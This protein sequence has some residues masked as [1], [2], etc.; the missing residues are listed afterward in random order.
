MACRWYILNLNGGASPSVRRSI[1]STAT[2]GRASGRPA[3]CSNMC[4]FLS[5]PMAPIPSIIPTAPGFTTSGNQAA[6]PGKMSKNKT[7]H[8]FEFTPFWADTK[9]RVIPD[10]IDFTRPFF[11][12]TLLNLLTQY[13]VFTSENIL[14]VMRPYQIAAT[15]QI[16]SKM[17]IANNYKTYGTIK[18]G[19]YIWH[20]TGSGKPLTSFKTAQIA[21][22]LPFTLTRCSFLWWTGRISDYQTMKEYD[23]F[24]KGRPTATPPPL[25]YSGSWRIGTAGAIP[26][27][28]KSLS[29]PFRSCPP[30]SKE[31]IPCRSTKNGWSLSLTNATA[32]SS[33]RCTRR[34]P[35]ILRNIICSALPAR[36]FLRSMRR[37]ME[38]LP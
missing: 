28:V 33:G 19:G 17:E 11:S 22:K 32:A 24:E 7:N 26:T 1:R 38:S 10:L 23:R 15:E 3:G 20:T 18:G 36:R 13:C 16:L 30:L 9:N 6:S 31:S 27:N 25:F 29:P 35:S 4:R 37:V 21:S 34:L 8:S 5:F 2:S 12:S 14:L